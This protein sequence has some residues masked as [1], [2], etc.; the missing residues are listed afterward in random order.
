MDPLFVAETASSA[1]LRGPAGPPD[2]LNPLSDGDSSGQEDTVTVPEL[3]VFPNECGSAD[4]T[5]VVRPDMNGGMPDTKNDYP[6]CR[7]DNMA[8][9]LRGS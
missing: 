1:D 7:L 3:E 4:P 8:R 6:E 2:I 5:S 9:Q